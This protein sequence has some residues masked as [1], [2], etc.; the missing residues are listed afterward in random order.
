MT[1]QFD[2]L[3][4][5]IPENFGK[6]GAN[7]HVPT[8]ETCRKIRLLLVAGL[9][10]KRIAA[11]L[12]ISVPTL[13]KHYFHSGKVKVRHARE[14]ALAEQRART[15][16]QLDEAAEKGNVSAQRTLLS[17]IEGEEMAMRAAE[18]AGD[19][20]RAKPHIT[21]LPKGKKAML[22]AVAEDAIEGDPLLDPEVYH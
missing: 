3:G 6:P 17:V 19:N 10:N 13:R 18:A 12:G 4:H 8:P 16:L 14:M 5:P 2:L 11:E 20:D 7:G 21:S 1:Q 22:S 15:I 9:T